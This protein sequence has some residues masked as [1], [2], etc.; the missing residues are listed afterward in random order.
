MLSIDRLI[1]RN[2]ST[3]CIR[4]TMEA[5]APKFCHSTKVAYMMLCFCRR[6]KRDS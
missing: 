2:I 5:S 1:S 3:L 6:I 4:C